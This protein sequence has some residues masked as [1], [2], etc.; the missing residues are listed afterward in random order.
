ML[1]EFKNL[2]KISKKNSDCFVF[3]CLSLTEIK[4]KKL[5]IT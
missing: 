3:K 1:M 5:S 2:Q 4:L